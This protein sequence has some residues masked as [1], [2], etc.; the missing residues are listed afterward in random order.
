M[1][2][3]I[4]AGLICLGLVWMLAA[5]QMKTTSGAVGHVS[6]TGYIE[7]PV[8]DEAL[9][10]KQKMHFVFGGILFQIGLIMV[11][12]SFLKSHRRHEITDKHDKYNP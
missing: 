2:K 3:L 1:G 9:V 7:T 12:L 4:G 5:Y 10:N 11:T 6:P 8:Y